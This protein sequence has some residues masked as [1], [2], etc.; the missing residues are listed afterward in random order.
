MNYAFAIRA[1]FVI[2]FITGLVAGLL[3]GVVR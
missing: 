3:L 2:G 1:S